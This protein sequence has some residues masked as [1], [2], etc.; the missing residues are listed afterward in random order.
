MIKRSM[1]MA[2][3]LVAS[4]AFA[5][6]SHAGL[7]ETDVT[8]LTKNETTS[9]VTVTYSDA[10]VGPIT[11]L[12]T[13]TVHV[14]SES[15]SGDS[16]VITYSPVGGVGTQSS[17]LDFTFSGTDPAIISTG[18]TIDG[19]VNVGT[20]SHSGGGVV[21]VTYSAVPEPSTMALLGIGMTSFLAFRRFFNKRNPVV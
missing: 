14:L 20:G 18:I 3:G 21:A 2:A 9:D 19:K 5:S 15:I 7:V 6:A 11:I 12:G 1:F 4:L 16:V 17:E 13:T 8:L 10:P